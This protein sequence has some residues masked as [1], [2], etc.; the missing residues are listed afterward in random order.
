MIRLKNGYRHYNLLMDISFWVLLIGYSRSFMMTAGVP[1][2]YV[3]G[4]WRWFNLGVGSFVLAVQ[5]LLIALVLMRRLR[6]EYAEQLWQKAAA[7]L[8][9]VLALTPFLWMGIMILLGSQAGWLDWLRANPEYSLLPQ[10][11]HF[12]NTTDSI[13][14][15]Q[16]SAINFTIIKITQYF[17]FAFLALYKWHRWRDEH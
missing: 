1:K 4:S 17:P 10:H 5:F 12:R 11:A 14:I 6:D 7:S 13:G 9:R 2:V 8:V 15:D 3:L 16:F